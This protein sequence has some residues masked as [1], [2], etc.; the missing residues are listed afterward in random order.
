[1]GIC[2]SEK[3]FQSFRL[4]VRGKGGHSSVP[5]TEGD[6]VLTLARALVKLGEY[7]FPAHVLP[8]VQAQ[9]LDAATHEAGGLKG[10][11]ERAGRTAR[12]SPADEAALAG[13]RFYNALVRTTCVATMLQAAPQDNVL[14]TSAEATV[15][16]RILPDETRAQTRARLVET[17]GDPT[18]EVTE[19]ADFGV[20]PAVSL[21]SDAGRAI[22][23]VAKRRWPGAAV[24]PSM[25][26]GATDSRHLR[27]AGIS[28]FGVSAA[29]I[30]IE[31]A[32]RGY[33]AHGPN[34]RRPVRWL[35]EGTAYL[36]E[37]VSELAR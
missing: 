32:A 19:A 4:V 35:D 9:L 26:T 7:H 12:L 24:E 17:I 10:A 21:D 1:V 30:T 23:R 2:V 34:E 29:P 8:A 6:P 16:C 27:A 36:D 33:G 37:L 13:D 31:D 11:L 5:P 3:L 25:S 28:A 14:P 15:N 22:A 20:G 18:V